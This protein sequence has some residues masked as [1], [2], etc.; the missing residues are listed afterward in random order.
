[1]RLRAGVRS[2]VARARQ[3]T[4]PVAFL[5]CASP[6]AA[7]P[8]HDGPKEKVRILYRAPDECPDEAA[9]LA[10]VRT[11]TGDD[12]W[13]AAPGESAR[14]IEVTVGVAP[15]GSSARLEFVDDDGHP[16]SRALTG[17]SC[18]DAVSAIALVTALA[19]DSRFTHDDS[20][21]STETPATGAASS[22]ATSNAVS[23]AA[24]T[25]NAGTAPS[26]PSAGKPSPSKA[27]VVPRTT[28]SE[29]APRPRASRPRAYR[30]EMAAFGAITTETKVAAF[31]GRATFGVVW[32]R[33]AGLRIGIDYLDMPETRVDVLG[34][35][36]IAMYE[37]VGRASGC[38]MGFDVG[39]YVRL[40]PCAGIASGIVHGETRSS[41]GVK[42]TGS[43]NPEFVA[44]FAEGRA[45]VRVGDFFLEASGELRFVVDPPAFALEGHDDQPLTQK[46]AV[47]AFASLGLGLLL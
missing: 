41:P 16:V 39:A 12:A 38:P 22:S 8:Q 21:E 46:K 42:T 24:T 35:V 3:F 47:A 2:R 17:S 26:S 15:T 40:S 31:G 28:P 9:F 32:P 34:G 5:L 30:G 10:A 27:T 36:T 45:D 29:R 33:G 6:A 7:A 19:I 25:P 1:M 37:L 18:A 43:A 14:Q 13:E 23:S 20:Q 44:L 4:A 11:R